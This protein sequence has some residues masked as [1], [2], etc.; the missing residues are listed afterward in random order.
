MGISDRKLNRPARRS[1][2]TAL[3]TEQRHNRPYHFRALAASCALLLFAGCATPP[4]PA[5]PA[6]PAA[7]TATSPASAPT[8]PA[9]VDSAPSPQPLAQFPD[10]NKLARKPDEIVVAGQFFPTGTRVVTWMDAGGYNA[11][12]PRPGV[13]PAAV[14][15]PDHYGA[16]RY[17]TTKPNEK[18][19]PFGRTGDSARDLADLRENVDQFVLHY[20]ECGLSRV[21]F[22]VLHVERGLSIHFMLDIDG[23]IYQTLD[24]RER[25]FHAT[26][27]NSR[28]IGI[29]IANIG[30]H[31]PGSP[32]ALKRFPLWYPRDAKGRTVLRPVGTDPGLYVKDYAGRPARDKPVTGTIQNRPLQQYD[33]TPE[34]YAALTKLTAALARIF[35]AIKLDYPRDAAGK[36]ITQK[37]PDE[38]LVNYRGVIGHFHIQANKLDPGPAMDWDRVING[39]RALNAPPAPKPAEKK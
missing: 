38:V 3:L 31:P 35:P 9:S 28:S 19:K 6:V 26:T 17:P 23:T 1:G 16:R 11:Y 30:A 27:S 20:D 25:A 33:L 5:K 24:L 29:E 36:V 21:C 39:A 37:L 7:P 8:P 2:P 15:F 4:K 32:A 34:Q 14:K 18:E 22:K 13:P 12:A 10:P